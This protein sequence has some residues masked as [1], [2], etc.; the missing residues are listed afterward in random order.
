[1]TVRR[2]LGWCLLLAYA[3]WA[4]A[5]DG[6]WAFSA[7]E[8]GWRPDLLAVL[9]IALAA[10]LPAGDLPW[11]ALCCAIARTSVSIDAP[12]TNFALSFGMVALARM[13]RGIVDVQGAWPRSLLSG[14][15]AG[16]GVVWC[17]LAQDARLSAARLD[18]FALPMDVSLTLAEAARRA[19]STAVAALAL[20]AV[21]AHL[22]GLGPLWRRATWHVGAS[23]R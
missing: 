18:G 2:A 7:R 3:V 19:L 21:T 23:S 12:V 6:A 4:C 20:G 17:A 15:C 10:R 8:F 22:P 16:L 14:L 1:V 5:L 9:L 13:A 11:L